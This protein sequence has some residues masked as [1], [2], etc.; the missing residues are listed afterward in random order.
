MRKDKKKV[1]LISC[2]FLVVAA[3]VF[4]VVQVRLSN[5]RAL[6]LEQERQIAGA[7]LRLGAEGAWVEVPGGVQVF[8][9]NLNTPV[10]MRNLGGLYAMYGISQC[11]AV[12]ILA[13]RGHIDHQRVYDFVNLSIENQSR[14]AYENR[15]QELLNETRG[16]SDLALHQLFDLPTLQNIIQQDLRENPR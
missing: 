15:L 10:A 11:D 9:P 14:I 4:A 2:I 8:R 12:A 1:I 13:D 3:T 7:Y 6:I 16:N 5:E